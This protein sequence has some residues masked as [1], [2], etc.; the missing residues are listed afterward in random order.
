VASIAV[1]TVA[2]VLARRVRA[3]RLLATA[4][5]VACWSRCQRGALPAGP[6]RDRAGR[7]I[8]DAAKA[9]LLANYLQAPATNPVRPHG[10]LRPGPGAWLQ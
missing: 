7:L 10:Y 1:A 5:L 9:D 6:P 8:G 2:V 3:W 4:A